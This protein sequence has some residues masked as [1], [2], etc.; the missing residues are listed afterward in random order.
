MSDQPPPTAEGVGETVGE[1]KWAAVRDLERRFP[2]LDKSR[3]AFQ[4]ISEGERGLMGVGREPAR[5][6]A[7]LTGPL[8]IGAGA[9]IGAGARVKEALLLPGAT[10]PEGGVL[11]RGIAGD[12]ARLEF[13]LHLLRQRDRGRLPDDQRRPGGGGAGRRRGRVLQPLGTGLLVQP[14]RALHHRRSGAGAAA[15][16]ARPGRDALRRGGGGARARVLGIRPGP[17]GPRSRRDRRLRRNLRRLPCH[18]P[19]GGRP[20]SPSTAPETSTRARA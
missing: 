15:V 3:V 2:G 5:V 19:V 6:I 1:A 7:S 18:R 8:V 10:V 4:V 20:S 9:S 13:G 17:R 11:A 16:R 14:E 12:A